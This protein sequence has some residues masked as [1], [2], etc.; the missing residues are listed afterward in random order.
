VPGGIAGLQKFLQRR[1]RVRA[2]LTEC[3]IDLGPKI[4]EHFGGQILAT[5]HRRCRGHEQGQ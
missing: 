1:F 2:F 5:R 4:G 3:H